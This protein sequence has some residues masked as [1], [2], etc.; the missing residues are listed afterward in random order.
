MKIKTCFILTVAGLL[1]YCGSSIAKEL[2][3]LSINVQKMIYLAQQNKAVEA[4]NVYKD[5]KNSEIKE[6][7]QYLEENPGSLPPFYFVVISDFIYKTDKDKAVFFYNFGKARAIEDTRMCKDKSAMQQLF[8]YGM[9]APDTVKY[10]QSKASESG[11]IN[12]VFN[13]VIEWDN[14]YTNR[15]S[16]IWACYHGISAISSVPELL[17]ESE[18]AN[19]KADV[20]SMLLKSAQRAKKSTQGYSEGKN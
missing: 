3:E 15:V 1:F 11:Y 4:S 2:S 17:P 6:F 16:P 8:V 19:I 12:N 5:F 9:M 20:H 7:A 14:K 13:K 10:M 18:F